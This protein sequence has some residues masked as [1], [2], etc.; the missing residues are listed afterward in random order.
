MSE[1]VRARYTVIVMAQGELKEGTRR[2]P[3]IKRAAA[4]MLAATILLG[5]LV[6]DNVGAAVYYYVNWMRLQKAADA[7]ALAGSQYLPKEPAMA[8]KTARAYA[9]LNGIDEGEIVMAAVSPD[10]QHVTIKLS[11]SLPFYLTGVVLGINRRHVVATATASA[12]IAHKGS[13][14]QAQYPFETAE[15]G[16]GRQIKGGSLKAV[17]QQPA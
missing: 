10:G 3:R 6:I 14:T 13:E 15:D 16:P 2:R 7:A 4:V 11:R 9:R 8:V 12:G 17:L 5:A 1:S